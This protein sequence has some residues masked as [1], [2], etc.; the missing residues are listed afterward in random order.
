MCTRSS[1]KFWRDIFGDTDDDAS[2]FEGFSPEDCVLEGQEDDESDLDIDEECLEEL[3]NEMECDSEESGDE[4]TSVDVLPEL[5]GWDS[6]THPVSST[7]FSEDVGVF[8]DLPVGADPFDFF[9]LFF[10]DRV[11]EMMAVETNRY[12]HQTFQEK[13]KVDPRWQNTD[14]GEMK[15]YMAINIMMGIHILPRYTNYWSTDERLNVPC[16]SRLMSRVRFEKLG[17]YLHLNDKRQ[18]AARGTPGYDPLFKVRPILDYFQENCQ[19]YYK[20]GQDISIDEAMIKFNGRLG[21]KQ[22]IK[23]KPTPWG[24]KVWCS[25]DP[26]TGYLLDFDV[27]TGRAT[28]P[29]KGVYKLGTKFFVVFR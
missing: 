27:Y 17:Q 29:M 12:A 21:F 18:C 23:S 3:E 14:A 25:A 20:P 10:P 9:Q 1:A 2:D 22:Y 16:I 4:G 5:G 15:V 8:H 19:E 11:F 24:I 28:Q 6:R 26:R 7:S 13:G